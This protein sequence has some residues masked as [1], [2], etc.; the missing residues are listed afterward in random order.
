MHDLL[1]ILAFAGIVG[2]EENS[3]AGSLLIIIT[4]GYDYNSGENNIML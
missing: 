3:W 2:G 1:G 4:P